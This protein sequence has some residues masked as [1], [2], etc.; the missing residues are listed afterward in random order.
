MAIKDKDY[1][2]SF[3]IPEPKGVYQAQGDTNANV[4]YAYIAENI[5][6]ERGL[7]AT[8]YGTTNKLPALGYAVET[9]ERFYRRNR[10]DDPEVYVA[11]ANGMI[12][13]YT[14]GDDAWI[15][16]R[17]GFTSNRWSCVTYE[18]VR[19]GDTVDILIMS[20]A[21]D[22]MIAVYGDDLS[23]EEK[24]II[25]MNGEDVTYSNLKFA[26]L[27]RYAERIWG[28]GDSRYPDSIFYS[29]P[30]NPFDW[31]PDT[32]V[33]EQGGGVVN[34]PTWDG[35]SFVAITPFGGYLIASKQSTLYEVRG[36]DPSNFQISAAYGTDG[37][38]YGTTIGVDRTLMLFLSR[39]GIGMYNGSTLSLLSKN[40]L[41]ETM[42]RRVPG[43][44][45]LATACV[46]N[47]VYYLAL[48]V[49][50]DDDPE[51]TSNNTVIEFDTLRSTFMIR[52]GLN[53][54]DF[55]TIN[56]EIYCT[57]AEEPYRIVKYNDS[58]SVTYSGTIIHS[59]WE[60][61][62]L[63]LGKRVMKRDFVVRFTAEA[64]QDD[65]PINVSILT[66]TRLKM[67]SVMLQRHRKDFR[68]K[69]QNK[70]VRVKL[71]IES[72]KRAAGWRIFGGVQVE[73]TYDQLQ[74]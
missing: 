57:L 53:I 66:D 8:A 23:V 43:L 62:W 30:Y 48:A 33:P 32:D 74:R 42:D 19:N 70:G 28:I 2:S 20:N 4:S 5:R 59:V 11:A 72:G 10:P 46:C 67:R 13:T 60:T 68:L 69:I 37:P 38:M 7:L 1:E 18:A 64:D 39:A 40:A 24:P 47:H 34:H 27:G 61:P 35:E 29:K 3:V 45:Q 12:L 31:N 49:Q 58:E 56:G 73:Y 41:Y 21:S 6:T 16:R 14:S 71:R 54:K 65:V 9:L 63:D 36:T 15:E 50:E 44:E 26:Q 55:F 25:V 52:K 22:G 17:I 51:V